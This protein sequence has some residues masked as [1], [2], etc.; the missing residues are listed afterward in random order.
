M[1]RRLSAYDVVFDD[2]DD[3]DDRMLTY[4]INTTASGARTLSLHQLASF[5]LPMARD[6]FDQSLNGSTLPPLFS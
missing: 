6:A 2:D 3:N 1:A 4:M 5:M